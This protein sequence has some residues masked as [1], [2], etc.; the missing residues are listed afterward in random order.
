MTA[1]WNGRLG[2]RPKIVPNAQLWAAGSHQRVL[3]RAMTGLRLSFGGVMHQAF[4]AGEGGSGKRLSVYET[5][6]LL[7]AIPG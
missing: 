4:F 2:V 3:G 1:I 7:P 6:L 5:L